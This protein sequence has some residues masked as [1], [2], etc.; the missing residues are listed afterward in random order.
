MGPALLKTTHA[1]SKGKK[2]RERMVEAEVGGRVVRFTVLILF[3]TC[4][5]KALGSSV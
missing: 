5:R 2:V 4:L 3:L 1:L